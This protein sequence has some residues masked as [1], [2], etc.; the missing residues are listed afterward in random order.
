MTVKDTSSSF[1]LIFNKESSLSKYA[2][3]Y[4]LQSHNEKQRT[5]SIIIAEEIEMSKM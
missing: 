5:C 3:I 1:F 2:P 4:L